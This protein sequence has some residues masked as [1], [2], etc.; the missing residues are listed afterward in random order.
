MKR[1]VALVALAISA[2][3]QAGSSADEAAIRAIV[4][5]WQQFWIGSTPGPSRAISR[6]TPIGRTPSASA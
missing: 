3:A 5:H 4:G 6:T 2:A 1:V